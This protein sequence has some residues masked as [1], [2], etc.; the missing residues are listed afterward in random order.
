VEIDSD[1]LKNDDDVVRDRLEM[2]GVRLAH[3]L[4]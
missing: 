4:D 3:M 1:D 2:A